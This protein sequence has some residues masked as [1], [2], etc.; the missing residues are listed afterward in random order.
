LSRVFERLIGLETEY[1]FRF[2][3]AEASPVHPPRFAIYESIIEALAR[4]TPLAP[5]KHFKEG[6]FLANGG[7]VWFEAERPSAGGGLVEG[8]TPECRGPFQL[9]AH[10]RAQDQMLAE[11]A[12]ASRIDGRVRLIKNDRDF[13]DNVYGA[14]ENYEAV[15]A[16]G[17]Q[18]WL[19]RTGLV[20]LFPVAVATWLGILVCVMATLA[21]FAFAGLAYLL[22]RGLTT[23]RETLAVW[24]FGR[25]LVD[26]RA[27]CVHV[28]VWLEA[29]LQT[30]TRLVTGPLAAAL[31]VVLYWTAFRRVRRQ[32][33][34]FLVSRP[35]I[36][37][38][39]MVDGN[40]EFQLSDKA[41]A[42]NCVLGFGGMVYDRPM[43]T[44][45][46]FFKTIYAEAWFSPA[47]YARLFASRQRLQISMGDSNMCE[48]A[49]LLRVGTTLLVLDAIEAG[50]LS[51]APRLKSPLKALHAICRDPSLTRTV[52]LRDSA[53]QTALQIQRFYYN[54]CRSFL[55]Q[56]PDAPRQ[57]WQ[58]LGLWG[59]TLDALQEMVDQ[60]APSEL[61]LGSLDWVSK[62]YLLE[63][64]AH[65]APWS[66]RKKIDIRYHELSPDGYCEMLRAAGRV[67]N[68]LPRA[69]IERAC[70]TAPADSPATMRGHY[71]REFSHGE[72]PIAVNWRC[73][74]I[75]TG[76]KRKIV[77]LSRYAN[78]SARGGRRRRQQSQSADAP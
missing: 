65:D 1:A 50:A 47:E 39:G 12:E 61:L 52:P 77:R 55:D 8:A 11:A 49:E 78:R 26:G 48:R 24:L 53:A 19:W 58:V 3:Q 43:F 23:H 41:P 31:Y 67:P 59:E 28:P 33:L 13:R 56:E 18:L 37:G 66:E 69:R 20:L 57:A 29:L 74:V 14:Q 76:W 16:A 44:L 45:G 38:A 62:Q 5:A 2:E 51:E 15:I 9:L 34:P 35:L 63:Q 75:G 54:A 30:V 42:M 7:A 71:I 64:S 40:G 22:I 17:P 6:V 72:Q 27:T 4:Q 21:Y 10:Q 68:V 36:A 60:N 70:R 73:I 32:M 46:H 25:D